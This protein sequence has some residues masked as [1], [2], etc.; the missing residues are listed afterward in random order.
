MIQSHFLR[1]YIVLLP[2]NYC[3]NR[4]T[5]T[6]PIDLWALTEGPITHFLIS[7]HRTRI[8]QWDLD[9]ALELVIVT[10]VTLGKPP[11]PWGWNGFCHFH[12]S[13]FKPQIIFIIRIIHKILPSMEI[14]NILVQ[15]ECI[16]TWLHYIQNYGYS[17]VRLYPIMFLFILKQLNIEFEI[18]CYQSLFSSRSTEF[19]G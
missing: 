6:Y 19:T 15:Y 16:V 10:P 11:P 17:Y 12:S 2:R 9:L 14:W 4:G 18:F 5:W 1:H 3:T 8:V 13:S 7:F